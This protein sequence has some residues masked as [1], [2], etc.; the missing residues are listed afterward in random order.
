MPASVELAIND[1]ATTI[2]APLDAIA[3]SVQPPCGA[4]VSGS[5]RATRRSVQALVRTVTAARQMRIDSIATPVEA[6]LDTVGATVG[7]V[8]GGLRQGLAANQQQRSANG[9]DES[10]F[11][12]ALPRLC[13]Q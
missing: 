11:H 3:F 12:C 13:S 1:V 7:P 4:V 5:S 2:Q 10:L 6:L 8:L 9:I